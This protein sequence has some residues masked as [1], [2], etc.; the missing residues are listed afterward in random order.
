MS[1]TS[2][3]V[4]P[5]VVTKTFRDGLRRLNLARQRLVVN[6]VSELRINPDH[7]ASLVAG[8]PSITIVDIRARVAVA[9]RQKNGCFELLAVA[10]TP[11]SC[12]EAC[13]KM[14]QPYFDDDYMNSQTI[15]GETLRRFSVFGWDYSPFPANDA[16]L[17][18]LQDMGVKASYFLYQLGSADAAAVLK[19]LQKNVEDNSDI[20]PI[21]VVVERLDRRERSNYRVIEFNKTERCGELLTV[22][23]SRCSRPLGHTGRHR[24]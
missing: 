5:V 10:E 23:R 18:K 14:M 4:A 8:L 1:S 16:D 20:A 19:R 6:A 9:L 11:F 15:I 21:D 3:A 17:E 2:N 7:R 13:Q 22:A 24:S 12:V